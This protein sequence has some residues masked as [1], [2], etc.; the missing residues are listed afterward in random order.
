MPKKAV[1]AIVDDDELAREGTMVL[2][3]TEI[4]EI[5]RSVIFL[6]GMDDLLARTILF[7]AEWLRNSLNDWEHGKPSV[8]LR[9][10]I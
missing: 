4:V 1:I 5:S 3:L 6:A 2:S 7:E 9:R 8:Q 10:L